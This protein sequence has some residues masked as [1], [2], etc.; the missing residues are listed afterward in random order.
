[1]KNDRKP[2]YHKS[3]PLRI[4]SRPNE[5]WAVQRNTK[6]ADFRSKTE[7]K[8]EDLVGASFITYQ[9]AQLRMKQEATLQGARAA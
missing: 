9:Q 1:M 4:I 6:P 7:D 2:E 3:E 8:W 5:M